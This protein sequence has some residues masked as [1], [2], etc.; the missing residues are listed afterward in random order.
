VYD[1]TP[2]LRPDGNLIAAEARWFGIHTPTSEVHSS[3][4]GFLLQGPEGAGLDTPVGWRVQVDRA[5]Q[6]DTTPYI[7]NAHQ[8]LGHWERVDARAYP[9]GWTQTAFDDAG[10]DDAVSTGPADY[11]DFHGESHPLQSLYPRDVPALIEEPRRFVRTL[12]GREEDRHLFGARPLGWMLAK[13]Q[14]GEIILDAGSLTTGYPEL[15][16]RGGAD[17]EVRI[18]YGESA[19]RW[20]ER[21]GH[22]EPVKGVRDDLEWGIVGGYRDIVILPGG[23]YCYEPFHWRTFWYIRV[24]VSAGEEPFVLQ[25]ARYRFTSYPQR[26]MATF[27]SAIPDTPRM[28]EVS[29]RS[30]QLCA[31]ETYEDCP[32]YEQLNYIADS[33]L[34]ALCSL[35]LAGETALPRRT[36]RL[37]RDSVRPDG[38]VHSRVPSTVPQILPYFALLWVL[39]VDDYWRYVGARDRS[40]V[41]STLNVVDGVLWFYRERLRENGFVGKIPPWS[42]VDQAPGWHWGEPPAVAAGEST[43]LT[44]L[45]VHAL[46]VAIRLHSEAG[47]PGD[48]DRWRP[49]ADRLRRG[50]RERAWSE[51]EGLF[52]EG[53]G[54][55][56]DGFS[57]HSQ[58]LAILAD[59]ATPAQ[60]RRILERLT[61]DPTLHRMKF[62]QSY[63]LARALEKAGGYEAFDTHVLALWREALD[64][65]VSTWPEYPDPTRSD[66][67]AW[68]A[69][70]AADF[71]TCVL[72]V[73]PLKP[74]FAQILIAPHTEVCAS[75]HGTAPTPAGTV[76]VD[77]RKD[78]DRG[79][80]SLIAETPPGIPV[81]ARL[82]GLSPVTYPQGGRIEIE[83]EGS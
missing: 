52:L 13:G 41:R 80:V 64:R 24:T 34:Q 73:Q 55:I 54:R 71:I 61:S 74:G 11:W 50:V 31:H 12:Q 43:Y 23:E 32:Y 47:D 39:M 46:D 82:G 8:F 56:G 65:N 51:E 67:H 81:E 70:I 28:W 10:W 14:S 79:I 68:S 59:V 5:V 6:P 42:M 29:W 57:Q 2:Y 78:A 3:R 48:A 35:V 30:L 76:T 22:R 21:Y 36:I 62:M 19:L 4:P 38:L 17:R 27:E 37:F 25:D 9:R 40:F 63:Y 49:V 75:A 58:V 18:I 16:F 83:A 33:R 77:W 26:L 20:A 44:C 60:S 45:Y 69:W 1:L 53:P 7:S 66:C 15:V 72:G